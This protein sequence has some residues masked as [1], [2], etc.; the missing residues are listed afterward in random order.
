MKK[1]IRELT[2]GTMVCLAIALFVSAFWAG[3]IKLLAT[4]LNKN[5]SFTVIGLWIFGVLALLIMFFAIEG[6]IQKINA[7]KRKQKPRLLLI[8]ILK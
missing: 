3:V 2:E 7:Y 5:W 4:L 1:L 6:L 8:V